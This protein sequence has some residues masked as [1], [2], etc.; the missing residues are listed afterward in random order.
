V[1][2]CSS[3]PLRHCHVGWLGGGRVLAPL[4]ERLSIPRYLPVWLD[5]RTVSPEECDEDN[6]EAICAA[7]IA[8]GQQATAAP[9]SR[10][11]S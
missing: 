3:E 4:Q 11:M 9:Y 6:E 7:R 8:A 5:S 10:P 1:V 2:R